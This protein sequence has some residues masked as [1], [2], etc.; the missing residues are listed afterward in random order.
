M[1]ATRG[2]DKYIHT[3]EDIPEFE[4][5]VS[6]GIEMHQL[7]SQECVNI[8][9]ELKTPSDQIKTVFPHASS[10]KAWV[11]AAKQVGVDDKM[12]FI[13]PGYGNLVS[14][15]VPAALSLATAEGRIKR[16]DTLAG[17]VGSAGMSFAAYAFKY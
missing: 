13:Y 5:F 6:F 1:S 15:S 8:F 12:Y 10:K 2:A 4:R 17:W 9:R 16:G 14:A 7:G 3:P 11:D